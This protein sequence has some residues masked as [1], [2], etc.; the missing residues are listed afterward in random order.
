MTELKN[1]RFLRALLRQPVDITP[2][3]MMRQAGR[4][5]PEY[6]ATRAKAGSFMDLCKNPELACEVTLQPLRAFPAGRGDPVLRHPDHPRCHGAGPVL[7]RGRGAALRAPGA[8]RGRR[9][10][11]SACPIRS[12]SW[13]TSWTRCAPIR[14]ELDGRVP[15]I[16][17]S[18]SPWTL[19]TYMVEGGGTKTFARVQG[20]DVRSTRH[21]MHALL[22]KLAD[23]VTAYLNAQIAAGAQARDDLRHLGRRAHAARLP[24]VLAGLH[25]AHR[26]RLTRERGG[27][28]GAGDP[29][30][31]GRRPVARARWPTPAATPWAW[32]GPSTSAMRATGSAT[33]SRCRATSIPARCMPRRS[34]PARGRRDPGQLR[35][36]LRA[37]LQPRPRHPP[38]DTARTRRCDGRGRARTERPLSSLISPIRP[39]RKTAPVESLP[40]ASFHGSQG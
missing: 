6:R 4:Y 17:F 10:T 13:A 2:V 24:G 32:T 36:G 11:R 18:G 40:E 25:A 38:G 19:A 33:A 15:L 20:H 1:D 5:L 9:S 23:A 22:G 21:L 8:R 14:R 3:W 29:V 30:H 35:P 16:G 37:R 27:P 12:R 31:Q 34:D 28:P 39:S 7:R 26:R